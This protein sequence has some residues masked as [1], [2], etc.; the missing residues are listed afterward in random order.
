MGGA[1]S[2][3]TLE[4]LYA[5]FSAILAEMDLRY[6]QRFDSQTKALEAAFSAA[7]KAVTAALTAAEKAVTK[8]EIAAEKRFDAVNEFRGA[9]QDIIREQMPRAEAEQRLSALAEKVDD[10]KLGATQSAGRSAGLGAGWVYVIGAVSLLGTLV[11]IY[12]AVKK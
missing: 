8:A 3:W 5:H 7:D 10:L 12:A 11:A 9:Y 6:Q 1:K 4:T 2:G